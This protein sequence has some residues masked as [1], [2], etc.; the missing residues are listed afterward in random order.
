MIMN[1][2]QQTITNGRAAAAVLAAGAGSFAMGLFT[3]L[4]AV[5]KTIKGFYVFY[6]PTGEL[7]GI[8]SL[9]VLTWLTVWIVLHTSWKDRQIH[10]GKVFLITL[11]LIA[12][13]LLGTFPP[14]FAMFKVF[15]G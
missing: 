14:F 4:K 10:F 2:T 3:T 13:G 9:A 15:R 5:S 1:K 12:L 11:V 7:S 6:F 8:S